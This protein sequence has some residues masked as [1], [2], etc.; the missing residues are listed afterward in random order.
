MTA[1]ILL[2]G[3]T[4]DL[5]S[6]VL[7]ELVA[8][9]GTVRCLVRA[10][11]PEERVARL[12]A[13]G[14][15]VVAVDFGKVDE[16]SQA[17]KGGS[18]VVSAVSGL[19]DVIVGLQSRLLD[20]AVNAGVPRFIPSDFAIDYRRVPAGEN[21]NLNFR[22]AFREVLERRQG[23]IRVTSILSGAFMDMLTGVAPFILFPIRRI[24]CWGDPDQLMDWTTIAD[25]A[26]YTAYAALDPEAPRYLK[27]AGEE[28]SAR[29]LAELMSE[30]T[31]R[32]YRILRPGGPGVLKALISMTRAFVPGRDQVYPP[33][34]GMQ[35]MHSMYVGKAK[36]ESLDNGRYPVEFTR[37]REL[38]VGHLAGSH[39]KGKMHG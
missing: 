38:L 13:A 15:E 27:I 17:C 22:D 25:T 10:G 14:A 7:R 24:L 35:Y 39:M 31:G 9:R 1:P 18:V 3:A 6:R 36:F 30:L 4:G 11:G 33:W 2:V 21:R 29:G 34:Q 5:G 28:I 20:A 12:R 23:S 32:P 16:L 19:E 26:R 37:A 8:L